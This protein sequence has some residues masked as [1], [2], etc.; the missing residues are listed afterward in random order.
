MTPLAEAM[1]QVAAGLRAAGQAMAAHTAVI[2]HNLGGCPRPLA[3]GM[4][5]CEGCGWVSPD[6][7]AHVP[8]GGGRS[9][10]RGMAGDPCGGGRLGPPA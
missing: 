4:T 2:A 3:T 7:P 6:G 9:H 5:R 1:E 8:P 10:G